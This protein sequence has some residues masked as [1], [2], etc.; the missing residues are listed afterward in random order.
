MGW[1][2]KCFARGPCAPPPPH[3]PA[4][5]RQRA[6]PACPDHCASNIVPL[7][8]TSSLRQSPRPV[9]RWLSSDCAVWVASVCASSQRPLECAARVDKDDRRLHGGLVGYTFST[10][11]GDSE[12]FLG[13]RGGFSLWVWGLP[14]PFA[15]VD[16]VESMFRDCGVEYIVV[17]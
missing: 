13:R 8:A 2:T 9:T 3:V 16:H 17:C 6:L 1:W 11:M 5:A 7:S 4:F 14:R 10:D 15:A 12:P